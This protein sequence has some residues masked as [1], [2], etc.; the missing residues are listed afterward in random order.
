[1]IKLDPRS[2]GR[3]TDISL[4]GAIKSIKFHVPHTLLGWIRSCA[5]CGQ[6]FIAPYRTGPI[7]DGSEN[8][9][10]QCWRVD[11]YGK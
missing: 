2:E 6:H 3:G 5:D 11:R 1:M 9:C 4:A 7:R 10:T 8:Q